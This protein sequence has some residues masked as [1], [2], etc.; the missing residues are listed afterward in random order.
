VTRWR[1][2]VVIVR[3]EGWCVPDGDGVGL[4]TEALFVGLENIQRKREA[5][6]NEKKERI[7]KLLMPMDIAVFAILV[8]ARQVA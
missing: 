3:S 2:R 4:R 7:V 5:L 6:S 1:A 8:G